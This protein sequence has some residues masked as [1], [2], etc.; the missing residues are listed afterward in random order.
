M[1][2]DQRVL[3]LLGLAHKSGKTVCGD[4]TA[5]RYLQRKTVPVLF[6]ASDC[7]A[8]ND[9]KYR[10]L[11]QRKDIPVI[12]RYTKEQLGEAVGKMRHVIIL[13]TDRGFAKS[14]YKVLCSMK[15]DEG[16]N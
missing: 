1:T 15:E 16:G 5:E 9:K 12:D 13:I 8:D 11:A 7:G 14:I 6:L 2:P 10:T 3:S 4:F